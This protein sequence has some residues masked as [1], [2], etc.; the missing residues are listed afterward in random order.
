MAADAT[1][2]AKGA[3]EIIVLLKRGEVSPLD[4]IDT[5][6]QRIAAVDPAINALPTLCLGRARD[7][8][9]RLMKRKPED[10]GPL[11]GLPV[12]IKDLV[13]VAGV[14]TTFGSPIF[15]DFIPEESESIVLRLEDRGGIVYA[16]S[17]TPEFGAGGHT[18]NE[19]FGTTAN[20]WNPTRSAGGSS[21]GAAAA[22][23]TGCAWLAHGSDMAGSLRTPASFC[24]VV[25]LRPSPGRVPSGPDTNPYGFLAVEG[26]MARSVTD[27][28]LGLDAMTGRDATVPFA[29]ADSGG[30]FLAAARNPR[31]PDRVA[32]SRDLGLTVLDPAVEAV[33]LAAVQRLED[34]GLD[35]VEASPDLTGTH[36]A[37]QALRAVA[38]AAAN[39]PLLQEHRDRL[40]P[41]VVWNIEQGLALTGAAIVD[42]ERERARLFHTARRFLETY[43]AIVCPGAIVPPFP[44]SERYVREC[45]G[46]TFDSYFDWLAIA[47]GFT[48][49]SLP[50]IC[51]PCGVTDDGL[52]VGLQI[53]GRPGGEAELIAMARVIEDALGDWRP[54]TLPDQVVG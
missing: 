15:A 52:P 26:P 42:A 37:F 1:L 45:N 3:V 36:E 22:L 46:R 41:E 50:V 17:N 19:V 14:R 27:A 30:A 21:G 29:T 34:A 32:F 49:V 51:I 20:P 33:F 39:A 8:A 5:L 38:Y 10:R 23:A 25:G 18:F 12:P 16:K 54:E 48:L 28:A 44:A 31:K 11:A 6:E 47:Y 43:D 40:K 7:H 35:M 4:L 24:G 53:A 9:R 2:V 13:P